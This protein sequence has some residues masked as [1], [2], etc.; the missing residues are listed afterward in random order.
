VFAFY[1]NNNNNNNTMKVLLLLFVASALALTETEYQQKFTDWMQQYQ[2]S[3]AHDAFQAKYQIWK[4]NYNYIEDWNAAG[5]SSTLKM[6]GFGDL[7]KEEFAK[8]YKGLKMPATLP[9]AGPKVAVDPNAGD[10][11]WRT[12]GAVTGIKNQGQCGSC[13]SFSTTGSVEGCHFLGTGMLVSLSEQNLM[14]CSW[15]E[16]N[17]GCDGGLMTQAMDYIITNNNG[18]DTEA[19][20]PYTAESSQTCLFKASNIGS[21]EASYVN[22]N[23]GDEGDLQ[24]KVT[25]GPTSVA[26]DASQS[27]FQFYS[28]GVYSDPNCSSTQLDH[29]VL[30]VGYVNSGS[31]PYWIVKNSWGTDWGM[32]GYINMA[33]NDNNMCGIATMAT[34][35]QKC[36]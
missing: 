13:W 36:T 19:S 22:V 3:Y 30:A 24:T 28:S 7:T 33:K 29:G 2:R 20:Y 16:G 35:P 12:K 17:E 1:N 11:D 8:Y 31:Q 27:S 25:S 34:L 18:V 4:N 6:N 26:I 21:H 15:S 10:V 14:D 9:P 32:A 23:Q 5:K